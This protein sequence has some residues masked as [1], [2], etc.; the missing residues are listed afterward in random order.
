M[1]SVIIVMIAGSVQ[2]FNSLQLMH[3]IKCIDFADSFINVIF[4]LNAL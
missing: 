3:F 1:R 4:Y 2:L